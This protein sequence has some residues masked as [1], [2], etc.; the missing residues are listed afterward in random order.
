[1][2]V[3]RMQRPPQHR[4]IASDSTL[5]KLKLWFN[6]GSE[7]QSDHKANYQTIPDPQRDMVPT[8]YSAERQI[9]IVDGGTRTPAFFSPLGPRQLP[10]AVHADVRN[11]RYEGDNLSIFSSLQ[12]TPSSSLTSAQ[13]QTPL[14]QAHRPKPSKANPGGLQISQPI[15]RQS[16]L[17]LASQYADVQNPKT[18]YDAKKQ[19]TP[20]AK[21]KSPLYKRNEQRSQEYRLDQPIKEVVKGQGQVMATPSHQRSQK[22]AVRKTKPQQ[23]PEADNSVRHVY[24]ETRFEDFMVKGS[25]PPLPA[26]ATSLATS[27]STDFRLSRPFVE[28][29]EYQYPIE[30]DA[31]PG[32][33]DTADLLRSDSS[34]QTWLRYDRKQGE[35]VH[36]QSTN[37]PLLPRRNLTVPDRD[38]Q[39]KEYTPCQSCRQQVHPSAAV[40]YNGIYQCE[41]CAAGAPPRSKASKPGRPR[42]KELLIP[43]KPVPTSPQPL[44]SNDYTPAPKTFSTT[45]TLRNTTPSPH[46]SPRPPRPRRNDIP[47]GYEYLH[48]PSSPAPTSPDISPLTPSPTTPYANTQATYRARPP[49]PINTSINPA[50]FLS[51]QQQQQNNISPLRK[52]APASSIYPSTPRRLSRAPSLPEMDE[53]MWR[54]TVYRAEVEE[55]IIDGYAVESPGIA[56]GEGEYVNAG[57]R[58]SGRR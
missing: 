56:G 24:R 9:Q 58:G 50:S 47:P 13:S 30:D 19:P 20:A 15:P 48:T 12:S 25:P 55:D 46:L 42:P 51:A 22:A 18:V 7:I 11:D 23:A 26:N 57:W 35:A 16:L 6:K 21:V 17:D 27:K 41:D 4:N 38:Q 36:Q 5:S 45:T 28:E 44:F 39:F 31:R 33:A 54:G 37:S 14:A 40:N 49:A 3:P 52:A 8:Q 43:R 34:V 32:T 29:P 2:D 53:G 10:Q 1:M